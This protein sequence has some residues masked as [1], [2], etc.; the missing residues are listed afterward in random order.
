MP[1][2]VCHHT[3]LTTN[4]L[5]TEVSVDLN[6]DFILKFHNNIIKHLILTL[7]A[8]TIVYFGVN[9]DT[10]ITSSPII[11]EVKDKGTIE[12]CKNKVSLYNIYSTFKHHS[13]IFM[14]IKSYENTSET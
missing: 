11:Q 7:I 1:A 8:K 5:L 3:A 14:K 6:S 2:V 13:G 9:V 10:K 12:N 4:P